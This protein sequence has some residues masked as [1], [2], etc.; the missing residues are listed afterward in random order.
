[1]SASSQESGR[2]TLTL[3]TRTIK[4][5]RLLSVL[6]DLTQGEVAEQFLTRGGLHFAADSEL[7]NA[8]SSATFAAPRTISPPQ[9]VTSTVG[10]VQ[11]QE[12]KNRPVEMKDDDEPLPW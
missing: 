5:L 7:K 6:K 12:P 10:G 11:S 4:A 8:K 2:L 9:Q 3:N 1:M